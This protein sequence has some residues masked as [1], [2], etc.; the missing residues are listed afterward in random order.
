M[1]FKKSELLEEIAHKRIDF[2]GDRFLELDFRKRAMPYG[3][4]KALIDSALSIQSSSKRINVIK[5]ELENKSLSDVERERLEAESN[6]IAAQINN[7]LTPLVDY[8]AGTERRPPAI[9][10][11][12]LMGDDD[13]PLPINREEIEDLDDQTIS[14]IAWQLLN[15]SD[16]GEENAKS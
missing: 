13:Q 16:V 11:W 12:D 2:S 1:G 6:Q 8:L 9:V 3:K 10:K 15:A 14:F 4:K 5:K 7:M